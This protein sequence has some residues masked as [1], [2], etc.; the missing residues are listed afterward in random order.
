M[1]W[2]RWLGAVFWLASASAWAQGDAVVRVAQPVTAEFGDRFT[3]SGTVVAQRRARLS[4]R[5]DGLLAELRVE[6]GDV[7]AAGELLLR[8]DDTVA[9]LALARLQA[10]TDEAQAAVAEAERLLVEARQLVQGKFVPTST[11]AT[12]Q[13]ELALAQAA[14]ASAKAA[15]AEQAEM[16]QRHRLPAPFAG[17]IAARHVERGEWLQRGGEA[18]ELVD[19]AALWIEVQVPQERHA[20]LQAGARYQA[21]LAG[22]P[23][24]FDADVAALLPVVDAA[25][26]TFLL[27]LQPSQPTTLLAGGSVEVEVILPASEPALA[28]SRDAL[29]RRPD[30]SHALFVVEAVDG[31]LV[32]RERSV[33][34]LREAA[35]QAAIA[36]GLNLGDRVVIRGN[37]ALRDGQRVQLDS[38]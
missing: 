21:R 12:R 25:A 38:D 32:A 30:G 37:E 2:A 7:V 26:R 8:Q 20:E 27:R 34:V 29:L 35:G 5:V 6:T 28:V 33:R 10:Q 17:V 14:L 1:Q 15:A 18:L 16:V 9:R 36:A 4:P 23:A 31:G 19:P 24:A 22:Q 13:A 3:L 11:V